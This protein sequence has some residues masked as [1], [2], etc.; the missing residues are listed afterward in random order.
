M[1]GTFA[2]LLPIAC[3]VAADRP[4]ATLVRECATALAA[5]LAH[6]EIPFALLLREFGGARELSRH[7]LVQV[8][9]THHTVTG[10]AP[11]ATDPV[12]VD[13]HTAKFDMT[14][15]V[16]ELD[17]RVYAAVECAA[18]LFDEATA[19]AVLEA[20]L[21]LLSAALAA[22]DRAART[23][24]A[25]PPVVAA[26]GTGPAGT[27]NLY[28]RFAAV[29]ATAPTAPAVTDRA[30]TVSYAELAVRARRVAGWL[31]ATGVRRGRTGRPA[32]P[33]QRRP[34]RRHP[35][36]RR[37]RRRVRAGRPHP[38]GR[39]YARHPRRGRDHRTDQRRHRGAGTGEHLADPVAG[40]AAGPARHDRLR[41]P[42]S[43]RRSWPTSST[44]PAPPARPKGVAVTH[45]QRVA[46]VRLD[47]GTAAASDPTTCGRMFH[48]LRLRLLGLGDVGC[49]AARRPAG[50]RPTGDRPDARLLSA[51]CWPRERV[52][53]LS[54]TPSAFRELI[55]AGRPTAT[56]RRPGPALVVFG[57]EALDPASCGRGSTGPATDGAELVNMYGITETTVHV[58]YRS[59]PPPTC[60]AGGQPRSG[61]RCPTWRATARPRTAGP[62][63]SGVAGEMYV[64]GAGLARGYLGRP[65]LTAERF[66]PDPFGAAGARLYR[67]GDLARRLPDGDAGV[68][69][70]RRRPGEDPRLPHRTRRGRGGAAPRTRRSRR[71]RWSARGDAHRRAR[72]VGL[73]GRRRPGPGRRRAARPAGRERC[74][75]T[76]CRRVRRCWTA[77]PLTAN[78]K[79]DRARAARARRAA[80]RRA[81][82]RAPAHRGRAR[83]SP[84]SGQALLGPTRVGATRTTSSSAATPSWRCGWS[85]WRP[86]T[87]WR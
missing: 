64:G 25:T 63:R 40:V 52:T 45:A 71:P 36:H 48:S 18:E 27:D 78:G 75:A 19:A 70:P 82:A 3:R 76:W 87:A 41:R 74:P 51:N 14:I 7:P 55:A 15:S 60:D 44:P 58:T 49:A 46:A 2:N 26:P 35:R 72:L 50:R 31:Q 37:R 77:L 68:P 32:R 67:T 10:I 23:L 84:R 4:F 83:P 47:R 29:A 5:D 61:G 66:V 53:V 20:Y 69:R 12:T 43:T 1:V 56:A 9:F 24:A 16:T 6:E 59:S 86:G 65:E 28:R 17:D 38:T 34:D 21:E 11:A 73:R 13:D 33:A 85:P 22:P 81:G 62:C 54:Q 57:G 30:G 42:R 79:V 39:P 80:G 8:V